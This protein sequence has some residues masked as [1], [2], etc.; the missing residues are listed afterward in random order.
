MVI[1]QSALLAEGTADHWI[2][3]KR[4]PCGG[5]DGYGGGGYYRLGGDGRGRNYLP[6]GKDYRR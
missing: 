2:C 1:G 3:R 5:G 4:R 6:M